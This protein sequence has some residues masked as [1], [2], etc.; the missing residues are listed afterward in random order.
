MSPSDDD[1]DNEFYDCDNDG[2]GNSGVGSNSVNPEDNSFIMNIPMTGSSQH[3]RRNSSDS[4]ENEE[5]SSNNQQE[6]KQ[7]LF[8]T[9]G[10]TKDSVEGQSSPS[11][12]GASSTEVDGQEEASAVVPVANKR[13]R[14]T[15]VPDKPNHP[16]NLWSIMK[17]CIGKDLSKIPMPVNFR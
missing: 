2:S 3:P 10:A 4:S 1:E 14:R 15:R 7:V 16:L 9:S 12:M 5:S 17:N 13:V 8:V 6:T 11:G